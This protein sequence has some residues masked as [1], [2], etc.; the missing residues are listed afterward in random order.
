MEMRI[1]WKVDDS[2]TRNGRLFTEIDDIELAKCDS[3]HKKEELI[4]RRV[5]QDFEQKISWYRV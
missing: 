1:E 2:C 5:Q 4:F 3:E